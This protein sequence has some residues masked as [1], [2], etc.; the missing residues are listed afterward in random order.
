MKKINLCFHIENISLCGGTEH[1]TMQVAN[2]I[3]KNYG[4]KYNIVILTNYRNNDEFYKSKLDKRIP[5]VTLFDKEWKRGKKNLSEY[6]QYISNVR[7]VIRENSIDIIISVGV[8]LLSIADTIAAKKENCRCVTWEHF[9]YFYNREKFW[10]KKI[11][12]IAK[13]YAVTRS[14]ALVVLT[15][16]DKK[17]YMDNMNIKNIIETIYNPFFV[18]KSNNKYDSNSNII[19]SSGRLTEQKGFDYLIDIA[20]IIHNNNENFKWII[21]GEGPKRSE[22]EA[23]VR[24]YNLTDKVEFVGSVKNTGDFYEKAKL[25]AMTSRYEGLPLVLL[26]AKSYK[27]PLVS[28]DCNCGPSE[29]IEDTINGN[30][31]PEGDF[32]KFADCILELLEDNEKC[33]RYSS[34]ALNGMEFFKDEHVADCWD[35]LFEKIG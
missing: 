5:I 16:K 25:F 1:V 6:L 17:N 30:L 11:N 23:K 20:K 32:Y 29:L 13:K 31:V 26:E 3:K 24:E 19:L 2:I 22:L 7:K 21:L 35:K 9:N 34:N 14:D 12:K 18:G 33:D 4:E 10:V 8:S 27:L 15:Q 28:F